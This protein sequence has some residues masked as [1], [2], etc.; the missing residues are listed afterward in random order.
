MARPKKNA[1]Q[2]KTNMLR[3]R[4]TEDERKAI[5]KAATVKSLETSTWAR[6]ELMA[7]AKRLL[8]K[9]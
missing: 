8:A 6:F 4:L 7:L 5:D 3:I 1:G 9:E 2:A